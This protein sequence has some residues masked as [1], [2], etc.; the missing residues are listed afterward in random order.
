MEEAIA[1]LDRAV[2]LGGG[3][4]LTPRRRRLA[5]VLDTQDLGLAGLEVRP[6]TVVAGSAVPLQALVE[7]QV[8]L[9]EALVRACRLEAAWNLRNMAT[10]AGTIM[11]G[12]GRSPLLTALLA[13]GA[14]AA[15]EPGGAELRLEELL[16][17]R[18]RERRLMTRVSFDQPRA[19]A[20][21]QIARSPADRPLVAVAIARFDR[22]SAGEQ[23]RVALGGYGDQPLRVMD[24]EVALSGGDLEAAAEA[25]RGAF[26]AAEDAWASAAYRSDVAAVLVRRVAAELS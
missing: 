5:A 21:E 7:A 16:P 6:D 20:Y 13:L 18:P 11:A 4:S 15:F 10:L 9:P 24:A 1:L 26:S 23:Y 12:D 2:P 14:R 25:A 17:A 22:R 19:S 8:G 3:T